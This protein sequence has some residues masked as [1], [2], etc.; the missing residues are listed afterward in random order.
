MMRVTTLRLPLLIVQASLL[1]LA[2]HGIA[3]FAP[4]FTSSPA[5]H[6]V[7]QEPVAADGDGGTSFEQVKAGQFD[8]L[9]TAVGTWK[10]DVGRTIIDDKHAKTGKHCLQLTGGQKTSVT[11]DIAEEVETTGELTFRA[12]RW[13]ARKPFSFRIEKQTRTKKG[14]QEIYN[15]DA[16]VRVGRSF[17]NHVKVRLAD[18]GIEAL[19]FTCSSPPNTGI[20]IDDLRIAPPRPQKIVSVEVVPFTL[21]ALPGAQVSPLVKLKV[22]T[23]GQLN[24]LSLTELQV[25]FH[26]AADFVD[27]NRIYVHRG[28]SARYEQLP[29]PMFLTIPLALLKYV[30][31]PDS[32]RPAERTLVEGENTIWVACR[33]KKGANIDHPI[34][35]AIKQVTFSNGQTVKLDAP[36]SM[37]RLG[38]AVRNGGDDGVHTYRIP[39]LATTNKGTLIGV[40]DVRRRTGGDLPGDIDVGMSRSTDGGR[41]WESMKVIMDMGDDPE[42]RYDG[43]GDPAVLVDNNTGTIWVAGTWSHGNRSWRGSGPGLKPEETGQLMLVRSDDDGVTWSKPIN[44]TSQVKKPEWCFILQGPGK[45]ITMRDGTIVFAAQYQDPPEQN[46]LPHSTIIYSKDHGKTWQVGTGAFDDTTESQVVEI[47]PG[48]LMLNCRYNRKPVRVVMT[49]RDMGKTWQKHTTSERS[50]IEPGSCMASLIDVDAELHGSWSRKTSDETANKPRTLASPATKWLLFSNPDSTRGRHH[51]TIKAS[52]DRGLTWPKEHRLLLDEGNSAGYSCMSMIDEKTVG[53]LYEGSQAHMT[54]QRIPLSDLLS[55]T[56]TPARRESRNQPKTGKSAR[57]TKHSLRLPRVFGSQ[58]VL[59]ADS[60]IPVWGTTRPGEKVTVVLG[61]ERQSTFA[62][63]SGKW[64]L[65]LQA[66]KARATPVGSLRG[67]PEVFVLSVEIEEAVSLT[68]S[69]GRAS[70]GYPNKSMIGWPV[71]R[72][73]EIP[74]ASVGSLMGMSRAW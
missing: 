30:E 2:S 61:H 4:S 52:S 24:P 26:G 14:W 13:T 37:Q 74:L 16:K 43:I 54:F 39:G 3:A 34:G 31:K 60:K 50:L 51:I 64:M 44:I 73:R 56:G 38:V 28:D 57:P 40:Y 49:T 66:R 59:Q 67:Q 53:I 65:R 63:N 32:G 6:E 68:C 69:G 19:R 8:E 25:K 71:V 36:S 11:L 45:G 27:A 42:W 17:L 55:R 41:T 70:I 10:P 21:P 15:G 22:V 5:P 62:N 72:V 20:L 58:V 35:A 47:E 23:S 1:L 48:V 18:D 9:E 29:T 12:E 33:I 46:R 7:A